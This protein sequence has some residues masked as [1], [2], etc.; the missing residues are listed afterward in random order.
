MSPGDNIV[1]AAN[2]ALK[3]PAVRQKV[4]EMHAQ[5]ASLMDMIN[6][7]GLEDVFTDPVRKIVES[8]PNDVIA[9]IRHATVHTLKGGISDPPLDC[10][11]NSDQYDHATVKVND[12]EGT[13]HPDPSLTD[14]CGL[15]RRRRTEELSSALL[16]GLPLVFKKQGS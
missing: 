2:R 14:S 16:P 15:L 6:A 10:R 4:E 3:D 9:G 1:R 11:V 12:H 7:L 5:G 13:D 8:L